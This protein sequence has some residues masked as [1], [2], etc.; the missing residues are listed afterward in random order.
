M[1][2]NIAL[3]E[4]EARKHEEA[5]REKQKEVA[6]IRRSRSYRAGRAITFVPRKLSEGLSVLQEKWNEKNLA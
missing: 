5:A 6:K 1:V 4:G 2:L 3:R